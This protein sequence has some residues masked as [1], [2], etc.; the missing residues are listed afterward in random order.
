M[1]EFMLL[2]EKR[3]Y[4]CGAKTKVFTKFESKITTLG[5]VLFQCKCGQHLAALNQEYIETSHVHDLRE[6]K[7]D[8]SFDQDEDIYD[9]VED[10]LGEVIVT[11]NE[12]HKTATLVPGDIQ[13]NDIVVFDFDAETEAGK[14]INEGHKMTMK[15][16]FA[17]VRKVEHMGQVLSIQLHPHRMV[18]NLEKDGTLA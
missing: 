16:N 18:F 14:K 12:M 4:I 17:L 15:N 9:K 5:S 13:E 3:C 11:V 2:K 7:F 10:S 1:T 6:L 8:F